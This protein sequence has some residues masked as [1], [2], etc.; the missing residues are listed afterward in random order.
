MLLKAL[1]D[2]NKSLESQGVKILQLEYL[3]MD[4][5]NAILDVNKVS[6]DHKAAD[7]LCAP[8]FEMLACDIDINECMNI[9]QERIGELKRSKKRSN[10][11][12]VA[13]YERVRK[14]PPFNFP[15]IERMEVKLVDKITGEEK[16]FSAAWKD[17]DGMGKLQ[18]EVG[19]EL[20]ANRNLEIYTRLVEK[21]G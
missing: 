7:W 12:V 11:G 19:R 2:K 21:S 17:F 16:N 8:L 5:I 13:S 20:D 14:R 3:Q 9:L 6:R 4:V 1:E 10:E 15:E 18:K